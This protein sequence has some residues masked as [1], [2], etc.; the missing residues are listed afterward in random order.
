[1]AYYVSLYSTVCNDISYNNIGTPGTARKLTARAPS[2]TGTPATGR[3]PTSAGIKVT[4]ETPT[5]PG[6]PAK[7]GVQL[8]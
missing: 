4:A 5:A 1:M 3:T 7:A 6:K 2:T 8:Q